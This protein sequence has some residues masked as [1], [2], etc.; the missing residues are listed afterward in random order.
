MFGVFAGV[1][2]KDASVKTESVQFFFLVD[3]VREN[4][5]VTGPI[6]VSEIADFRFVDKARK[7]IAA[8]R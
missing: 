2:T 8:A 7:D 4:A 3:M 1:L 5:K 6:T